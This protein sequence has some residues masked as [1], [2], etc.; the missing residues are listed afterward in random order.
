MNTN[1]LFP[2]MHVSLYA[3]NLDETVKFYMKFM[4]LH[5]SKIKPGYVKFILGKT[6]S[7]YIHG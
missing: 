6:F 3:S 4:G 2:R 5:P 1:A 7:D